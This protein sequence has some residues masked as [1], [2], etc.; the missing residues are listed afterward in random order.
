MILTIL[1]VIYITVICQIYGSLL[2]YVL[3]KL[4]RQ[5]VI[6]SQ[7]FIITCFAGL[8]FSGI[9]FTAVSL[10]LPLGTILAQCLLLLPCFAWTYIKRSC[11]LSFFNGNRKTWPPWSV[12]VF[13]VLVAGILCV[14]TMHAGIINHPDTL[15]YHAQNI[16]WA[17]HFAA[18]PGIA[19][20]NIN[21][22][23]QSVWF[24]VCALFSF[25]FTGTSA[26]TF[27]NAAILIWFLIFLAQKINEALR[28]QRI[29]NGLLW[30]LLLVF[31]SWSYTQI[32][33]TASSASPDFI[34][35]LYIWLIIYLFINSKNNSNPF[36]LLL[37]FLSFFAITIKL[38]ALPC[39]LLSLYAWYRYSETKATT[40]I[41]LPILTGA[42]VLLPHFSRNVI[43]TG[44]PVFPFAIP[45][46]FDVDWKVPKNTLVLFKQYIT[47]Y[48]KTHVN[49][50]GDEIQAVADMKVSQWMPVWWRLQS[51]ADK[52]LLLAIP[53]LLLFAVL[54]LNKIVTKKNN[55]FLIC[56]L[57]CLAGL[58]FWFIQAPDPRFGF[59]FLVPFCGLLLYLLLNRGEIFF[60]KKQWLSYGLLLFSIV[61]LSY[62][63]YRWIYFFNARNILAPAGVLSV[64]YEIKECNGVKINIPFP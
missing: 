52:I 49:Y 35:A 25:S 31:A 41:F 43:S 54:F 3:T 62:T 19:H 4:T 60:I 9:L 38:S 64:T 10:L 56:L 57:L 34:A 63:A 17:E 48:A 36:Y 46:L 20:L 7:P 21:Y 29:I 51:F 12:P 26:L 59:G 42:F 47:G 18:V 8:A 6:L 14:L 37:V 11:I 32:R 27:M 45:D 30:L 15:T 23:T 16:R 40:K 28:L 1:A 55:R 39:I 50:S 33:L 22:G 13:M 61:T 5:P 44:Y 2:F 24:I 58:L 53:S